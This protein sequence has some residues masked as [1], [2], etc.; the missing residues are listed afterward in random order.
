MNTSL[1]IY[2][3]GREVGQLMWHNQRRTSYFTFNPSFLVDGYE[4][5]PI[6]ASIKAPSSRLPIYGENDKLYQK[7]PP[8]LADSLPD[9]WGNTL[10]ENWRTQNKISNSQITPIEKLIFIGKRGMGAFEYYPEIALP[11][12]IAPIDIKSLANLTQKIVKEREQ[13]IISPS[14]SVTY[15][16]LI[17]VGTSAGGRQPKAILAINPNSGEIRSGQIEQ[18]DGYEYYILKFGDSVRSVAEIEMTYNELGRNAGIT[19]PDAKLIEVEGTKHYLSKRFDRNGKEKIHTQTL[20]AI[21]PEADSYERLIWVC[22]KLHLPESDCEEVYRRMVFNILFNNTDDHNKNFSFLMDQSGVW[23][24]A[25][26]YDMTFIFDTG[27]YLPN[28]QHCLMCRG[29]LSDYTIHDLLLFAQDNGI[30]KPES[31]IDQV[32]SAAYSFRDIATKNGVK[33]IWIGR[34]E[35]CINT[36][37]DEISGSVKEQKSLATHYHNHT[38]SD[39]RIE[40]AYRGNYHLYAL[41]DGHGKRYVVRKGTPFHNEIESKGMNNISEKTLIQYAK[42]VFLNAEV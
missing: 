31:I 24:L 28:A 22:H 30:R 8:F 4:I 17:A 19:V 5:A 6:I 36:R 3:W 14:E 16:A 33:D 21:Y 34:I 32:K 23:K 11:P 18:P 35:Q 38:I 37:I 26:A 27:G 29:K 20:A 42:L 1:K 10:F 15:Q 12:I 41:I 40:A 7:L 13:A 2:L 39:I 9:S 25:P